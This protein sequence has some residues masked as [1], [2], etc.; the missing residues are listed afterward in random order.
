VTDTI[1]NAC[2]E[3]GH[4]PPT[5]EAV[6]SMAILGDL[7]LCDACANPRGEPGQQPGRLVVER[8][9]ALA[10][11][12][13]KPTQPEVRPL[14]AVLYRY[15]RAGGALHIVL[16]DGNIGDDSV[17]FCIDG[18]REDGD[19]FGELL[20]SVLLKMSKTQRDALSRGAR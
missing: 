10:A 5:D 13:D 20:A 11:R 6:S 9:E 7:L 15:H 12:P 19:R 8:L 16:D 14:I 1:W 2:E 4:A 3:C 17:R 18:A